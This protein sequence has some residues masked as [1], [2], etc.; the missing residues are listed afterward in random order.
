LSKLFGATEVDWALGHAAV[1]A[2]FA[3]GDLASVLDHHAG[4]TTGPSSPRSRAGEDGSLTQGT[5]GWAG[6]GTTSELP[7]DDAAEVAL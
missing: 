7:F 3:H 2:R 1:H 4:A 5:S 6:L